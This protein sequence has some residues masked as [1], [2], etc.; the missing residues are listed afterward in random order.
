LRSEAEGKE[1][2]RKERE[3]GRKSR[4]GNLRKGKV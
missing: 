3:K 2:K 1:W 4:K